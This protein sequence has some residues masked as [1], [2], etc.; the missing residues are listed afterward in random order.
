MSL[1][2]IAASTLVGAEQRIEIA[3]RNVANASTPGYK[4]EVAYAD[5]APAS[6]PNS[7]LIDSLPAVRSQRSAEQGVLVQSGS[8]LD[9]AISGDA[10]TLVRAG[11]RLLPS[12][13]GSFK[14]ADDGTLTDSQGRVL[15]QAGGGDLVLGHGEPVVLADGTVLLDNSPVGSIGLYEL[16]PAGVFNLSADAVPQLADAAGSELRQGMLERSNVTLSDEMVDLM[17]TQR[18]AESAAQ[19][20]RTYDQLLSQATTTFGRRNG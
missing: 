18:M 7:D 4:R 10:I 16:P 19:I 17:Q 20:V 2:D 11:D 3:G 5:A 8:P 15:Q 1:L 6:D 12:R 14:V 9:L 13:G